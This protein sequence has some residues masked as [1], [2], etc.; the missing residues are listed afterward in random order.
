M[1]LNL[2]LKLYLLIFNNY[3]KIRIVKSL[4]LII[5]MLFTY[6]FNS[7][8]QD[9]SYHR[10]LIVSMAKKQRLIDERREVIFNLHQE[11]F[12]IVKTAESQQKFT[13]EHIDIW[14]AYKTKKNNYVIQ[15]LSNTNFYYSMLNWMYEN[16][17]YFTK[18]LK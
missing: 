18:W 1:T 12:E 13:P 5:L 8:S 4:Y 6:S 2:L 14:N 16:K 17:A 3:L 7:F 15:D 11:I 9:N 10:I